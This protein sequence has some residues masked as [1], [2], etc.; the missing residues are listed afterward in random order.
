VANSIFLK[1][2][3]MYEGN[4]E[5]ISTS[6]TVILTPLDFPVRF[7]GP[8]VYAHPED[9]RVSEEAIT[10]TT[11]YYS[12]RGHIRLLARIPI[13]TKPGSFTSALFVVDTGAPSQL[14]F[15]HKLR[16]LLE[17][18]IEEDETGTIFLRIES[19]SGQFKAVIKEVPSQHSPANI[20]G[21]PVLKRL[22]FTL[23]AGAPALNSEHF[24]ENGF[25]LGIN[26]L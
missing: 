1:I 24:E 8:L 4:E 3:L 19:N 16:E 15:C 22:G 7:R 12:H 14:Y 11:Y 18:R 5:T 20:I 21:L 25:T 13:L 17:E 2:N 6:F 26:V 10:P 23:P 9:Y